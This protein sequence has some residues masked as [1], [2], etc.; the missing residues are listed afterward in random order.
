MSRMKFA[1][2]LL[3]FVL[4]TACSSHNPAAP[5]TPGFNVYSKEQDIQL[6]QQAAAQVRQQAEVVQV[7]EL[8]DYISRLG[9]LLAHQPQAG[10]FPYSFTMLN[11]PNINAFALP[12]GPT[13]VFS[14]LVRAADNEGQLA[15]VLAHEISH[16]ALRHGTSEASKANLISLP[17]A[18]AGAIIGRGSLGA[19]AAQ[20]GVGLGAN[21]LL[22]RYSRDAESQ[23]D[24]L[25]ARIMASAG[26]NPLEMA[27]FF[28]KLQAQGGPGAPQFLSDHPDP[29]NR[30]K[31]VEAVIATLPQRSYDTHVGD[32][33]RQKT[34]VA[35]LPPPRRKVQGALKSDDEVRVAQMRQTAPF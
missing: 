9:Q 14:G 3:G 26:Y 4:L 2:A 22:L 5:P 20:L 24:E 11:D 1:P 17:A 35:E 7:P 23:A 16:V 19:E 33:Q 21:A 29:G 27:R 25:G 8:Q 10:D 15:G 13:F 32:F 30:V 12:G 18:L 34:L 6:G 31:D 28:E